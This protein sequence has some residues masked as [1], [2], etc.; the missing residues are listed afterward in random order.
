MIAPANRLSSMKSSKRITASVRHGFSNSIAKAMIS[1]P[2]VTMEKAADFALARP[3]I[4][5]MVGQQLFR[6]HVN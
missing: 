4:A 3:W 6:K 5:S 1:G 2:G